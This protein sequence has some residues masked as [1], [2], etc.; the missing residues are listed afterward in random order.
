[1]TVARR[2]PESN[3]Q[4]LCFHHRETVLRLKISSWLAGAIKLPFRKIN[5]ILC[6]QVRRDPH[7][8]VNEMAK[9][10]GFILWLQPKR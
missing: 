5:S 6:E 8:G 2:Y 3:C 4:H 7:F 9:A 1:M 10:R